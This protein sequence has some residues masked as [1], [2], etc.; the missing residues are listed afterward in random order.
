MGGDTQIDSA[1]DALHLAVEKAMSPAPSAQKVVLEER[2]KSL[3][4]SITNKID[5]METEL[6]AEDVSKL[7]LATYTDM[8]NNT[9][10]QLNDS[11]R[12]LSKSIIDFMIDAEIQ[13]TAADHETFHSTQEK[14][15]VDLQLTIAKHTPKAPETPSKE[16]SPSTVPRRRTIEIERCKVPVFSG[17]SL[18][19]QSSRR[20]GR[21]WQHPTWTMITSWSR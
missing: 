14:R 9:E 3:R 12:E 7:P 5:T 18:I 20:G 17:M 4:I 19:T 15:L 8:L 13:T 11:F 2:M 6:S 21:R 16:H 1:N 10:K